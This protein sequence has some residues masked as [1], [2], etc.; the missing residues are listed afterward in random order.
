MFERGSRL[1][2]EKNWSRKN[3]TVDSALPLQN[4]VDE[5][6][7]ARLSKVISIL[8][9]DRL[10]RRDLIASSNGRIFFIGRSIK[11]KTNARFLG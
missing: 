2:R 5:T 4:T 11:R 7:G 10:W 9:A 8:L 6:F 1:N 3:G